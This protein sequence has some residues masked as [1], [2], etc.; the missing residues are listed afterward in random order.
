[1]AS[2]SNNNVYTETLVATSSQSISRAAVLTKSTNGAARFASAV[3]AYRPGSTSFFPDREWMTVNTFPG[4][5]TAGRLLVTFSLFS[6]INSDGAPI[7]RVYSDNG[8]ATWSSASAI[9]TE[10]TLQGSQPPYLPNGNCVVVYWNFGT[11]Q[12]P[13]ERLE[14]G[15]STD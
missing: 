6:N 4:T 12:Q 11:S 7:G 2:D 9:S 13:G 1:V 8:G 3:L 15:I 5:P 14:A 10:T